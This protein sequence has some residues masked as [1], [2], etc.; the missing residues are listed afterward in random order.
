M[1]HTI[2]ELR[3]TVNWYLFTHRDEPGTRTGQQLGWRRRKDVSL[4][5]PKHCGWMSCTCY[6]PVTIGGSNWCLKRKPTTNP[7]L[8]ITFIFEPCTVGN[9]IIKRW[10]PVCLNHSTTR[11]APHR[12][13]R[14]C[15]VSFPLENNSLL[16]SCEVPSTAL[17]L[18]L[19]PFTYKGLV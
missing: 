15:L 3:H 10:W 16:K 11:A 4:S 14:E 12:S 17:A 19:L 2:C 7:H 6:L 9:M 1:G 8:L 18:H 13:L 5:I